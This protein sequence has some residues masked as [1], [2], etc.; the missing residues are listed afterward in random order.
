MTH[1]SDDQTPEAIE[2][3]AADAPP[4]KELDETF[5]ASDPPSS[6]LREPDEPPKPA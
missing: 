5:P 1:A 3:P 6:L 2:Q 4:D